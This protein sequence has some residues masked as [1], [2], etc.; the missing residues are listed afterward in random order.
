VPAEGQSLEGGRPLTV[1]IL[2]LEQPDFDEW[3]GI[4]VSDAVE[5]ASAL[6]SSVAL[7]LYDLDKDRTANNVIIALTIIA[8]Y[9]M[10]RILALSIVHRTLENSARDH[11]R[12]DARCGSAE[13]FLL[14][15]SV[16]LR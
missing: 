3:E 11:G 13:Y 12:A 16:T 9:A 7:Y 8:E 2:H 1:E 10:M 15:K 5:G 4:S 6:Y 14:I